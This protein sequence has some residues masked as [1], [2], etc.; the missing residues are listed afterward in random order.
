MNQDVP[1]F[2][3]IVPTYERPEQLRSC[4]AAMSHLDYPAERFEVIVVDD[5]SR[6]PPADT[7]AEFREVMEVRL[8]VQENA[9]PAAARNHG[10]AAAR[11]DFLTFTDDDCSVDPNW[12]RAF[13]E[14]FQQTPD[15]LLGGRTLNALDANLCSATSQM[16][17]D[18]VYAHYNANPHDAHFFASNNIA[19]AAE[20]FRSLGGFDPDFRTSEDR[21]FCDHWRARGLRISYA[22][23]AVIHHAHPLNAR[24]LW[25]QH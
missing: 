8:L 13:A 10:A 6:T 14:Q 23:A 5:G 12:L 1:F 7:V 25:E 18:T 17:L 4:L 19:M 21:E 9:G 24:S 22:P 2:S 11:G 15:S 20:L 16:I 3:V